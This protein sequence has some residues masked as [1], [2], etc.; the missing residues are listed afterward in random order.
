MPPAE[1]LDFAARRGG[2]AEFLD[3]DYER[4]P[5][6]L[7]AGASLTPLPLPDADELAWLATQDD[8]E[9]R[10]ILTESAAGQPR[11]RATSGPFAAETLEA[12]PRENWTLL[13]HDVEKHLPDLR[14]WFDLVPFMPDWC[15]D[16]LMISVAAPGGSV[17]P[18]VDRYS[19]FLVQAAGARRWR[20][21][22]SPPRRAP[23]LSEDLE[24]VELF[25]DGDLQTATAGDVLYL[26]PGVAH[27]GIAESLC[28]TC[29]IGMRGVPLDRLDAGADPEALY[30]YRPAEPRAAPGLIPDAAIAALHRLLPNAD[31]GDVVDALGRA[32]TSPKPWLDPEPPADAPP[33]AETL[34]VHGMALLAWTRDRAWANGRTLP[35]DARSRPLF[36]RLAADRRLDERD[37]DV[38]HGRPES[39]ALLERLWRVGAFDAV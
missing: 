1:P 37:L 4:R 17:G 20:W 31:R 32:V 29:S 8:V 24:L 19:V 23:A 34:P 27:H 15:I 38:W 28:I 25:T 30:A 18:H 9:S 7:P 39:A 14:R 5:V 10:L 21:T 12:L 33:V 11:Y 35:L 16:D 36:A 26:P 2:L 6:W 13:L 22:P 3:A